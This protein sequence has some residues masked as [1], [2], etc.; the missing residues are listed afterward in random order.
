MVDSK[1]SSPL[2]DRFGYPRP[3]PKPSG[4]KKKGKPKEGDTK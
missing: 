2:E 1:K 4:G 3:A